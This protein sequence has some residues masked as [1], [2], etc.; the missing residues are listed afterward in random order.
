M[1]TDL[2]KPRPGGLQKTAQRKCGCSHGLA[3]KCLKKKLQ[4]RRNTVGIKSR[5]V[6]WKHGVQ[7]AIWIFSQNVISSNLPSPFLHVNIGSHGF[8]QVPLLVGQKPGSWLQNQG[9]FDGFWSQKRVFLWSKCIVICSFGDWWWLL[10][11]FIISH[12]SKISDYCGKPW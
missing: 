7:L 2:G 5:D 6:H 4:S 3:N 11:S 12:L 9:S 10:W 1:K 8:L